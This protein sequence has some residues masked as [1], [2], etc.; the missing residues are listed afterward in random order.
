[1]TVSPARGIWNT[2]D[3]GSLCLVAAAKP[4]TIVAETPT[5]MLAGRPERAS[6]ARI[7]A[8]EPAPTPTASP[9]WPSKVPASPPASP[10]A[11]RPP[12]WPRGLN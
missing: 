8:T 4:Y 10:P 7:P 9:A 6:A 5:S 1:L 11:N 3:V 2:S 12:V